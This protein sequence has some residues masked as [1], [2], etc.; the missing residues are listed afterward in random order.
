ML[1]TSRYTDRLRSHHNALAPLRALVTPTMDFAGQIQRMQAD[2]RPRTIY[3]HTPFCSHSCTFCNLNRR[4]EHPPAEYA[5]LVVQ[6]IETYAACDYV[7]EGRY[8]AVYFGGGTPTTLRSEDLRAILRALH[9]NFTLTENAE[10]T[11]E[12]TIDDLTPDKVAVF[13]EEGVN[14]FSVGVQTFS[15]KGRRVF[16]R[17]GT[18]EAAIAKLDFLLS[19]GFRNVG[20]D[21]IYNWPGQ[22]EECLLD[23]LAVIGALDLSGLS[24]YSLIMMKDAPLQRMIDSGQA[25]P[26]GDLSQEKAYFDLILERLSAQGFTLLELTKLVRAGRDN[27]D[28]VG[29]RYAGGDT[30]ALGAGAGGRLGGIA[31]HNTS[32]IDEYRAQVNSPT[33][34]PEMGFAADDLYYQIYRLI[35]RVQFG[36]LDWSD[37]DSFPAATETVRTLAA[38]LEADGLATSDQ[39]GF[40]LTN[41]GVFWGNNI[42]HELTTTLMKALAT[43]T[44]A[45]GQV[46]GH[47]HPHMKRAGHPAK[48]TKRK[49]H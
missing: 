26:L 1:L 34:L 16:G 25:L 14:R 24:F 20:I 33:G 49:Y 17:R 11:I 38:D 7:S 43:D 31:Y 27:Y 47:S 15:D 22:T 39:Y 44:E 35:G 45:P 46:G 2:T 12:T 10:V 32:A 5:E 42:G 19:T 28:Y 21:L 18:K 9:K 23:D 13:K 4:Y 40:S 41:D 29:I 3:V 30:L 8:G 6:E 37:F 48:A 36:R